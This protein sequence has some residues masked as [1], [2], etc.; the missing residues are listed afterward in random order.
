MKTMKMTLLVAAVSSVI[1]C[2]SPGGAGDAISAYRPIVPANT[3]PVVDGLR[4]DVDEVRDLLRE[5][6]LLERSRQLVPQISKNPAANLPPGDPL[7]EKV[8]IEWTGEA[9]LVVKRVADVA[10]W[11]FAQ[12]GSAPISIIVR[13]RAVETPLINVLEDIAV[14]LGSQADLAVNKHL[15]SIELKVRG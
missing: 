6:T 1:G 15:K 12:S 4:G 2:A 3:D 13:V 7:A 9:S 11:R 14:Q 8:T 10:G 5:L